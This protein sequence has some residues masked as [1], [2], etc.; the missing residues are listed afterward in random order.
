MLVAMGATYRCTPILDLSSRLSN[1]IRPR[2]T[3]EVQGQVSAIESFPL[4]SQSPTT[5]ISKD[6]NNTIKAH[7]LSNKKNNFPDVDAFLIPCD[8]ILVPISDPLPKPTLVAPKCVATNVNK[9]LTI[10]NVIPMV[11]A[12][13]NLESPAIMQTFLLQHTPNAYNS[14]PLGDS[15]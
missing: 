13:I 12:P 10:L 2:N 6:S 11:V 5:I 4:V 8:V 3:L 9:S 1:D 15:I 7:V 14:K